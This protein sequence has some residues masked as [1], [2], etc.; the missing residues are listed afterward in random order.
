MAFPAVM[1]GDLTKRGLAPRV[2]RA[3]AKSSE[4][5][6]GYYSPG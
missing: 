5:D 2:V 6:A 4:L 3:R 1:A